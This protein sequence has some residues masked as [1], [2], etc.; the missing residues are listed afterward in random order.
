MPIEP[1]EIP[2]A[3]P[4][5]PTEPPPESPPGNPRPEVPP[6]LREPGQPPQPQELPGKMPDELPSRTPNPTADG[7]P[8]IGNSSGILPGN[9]C[10]CGGSPG[11]RNGGGTSGR[12]LPGGLSCGGSVGCPGVAGGISGGSIGITSPEVSTPGAT[13]ATTASMFPRDPK[14]E[15]AARLCRR[16]A[17]GFDVVAVGIEHERAVIVRMVMRANSGCAVVASAGRHGCLVEGVHRGAVLCHNRDMQRLVQPAFAADPEIGLSV[18]AETCGRI[19]AV[20]AP[21]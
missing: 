10:G 13:T 6:P 9:S 4:G 16:V 11:S 17:D 1:P 18:G 20:S 5:Q 3:T 2:P 14:T 8:R 15:P 21:A 19:V 7:G 12:G